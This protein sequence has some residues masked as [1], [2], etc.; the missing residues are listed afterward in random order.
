[1][2]VGLRG[3]ETPS[4]SNVTVDLLTNIYENKCFANYCDSMDMI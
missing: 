4:R 2:A 3:T 1:M